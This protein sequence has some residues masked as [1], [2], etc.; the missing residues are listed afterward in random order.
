MI[1]CSD[2]NNFSSLNNNFGCNNYTSINNDI[3]MNKYSGMDIILVLSS[4]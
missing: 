1:N 4:F 2:I 3:E